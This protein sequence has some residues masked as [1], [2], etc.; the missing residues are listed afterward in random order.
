MILGGKPDTVSAAKS[1]LTVPRHL[2]EGDDSDDRV[3]H[4]AGP[5]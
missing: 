4:L 3:V 2:L 5:G 1:T